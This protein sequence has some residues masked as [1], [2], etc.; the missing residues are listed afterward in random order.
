MNVG[1]RERVTQKRVIKLF[2]EKLGYTFLGNWQYDRDNSNIEV[3]YLKK[4]LKK[5]RYSAGLISKAINEFI[6]LAGNQQLELYD[7]NK[8][9]YSALRYGIKVRENPGEAPKTVMLIDWDN[10]KNNEFYIAEEVTVN[11]SYVK[12]PDI[13]IYVNGIALG[14]I[15]LKKSTVSVSKGIRQNIDNQKESFIKQFFATMGLI[16]AGNDSEGIAYGVIETKEKYYLSWKEDSSALDETSK[17]IRSLCDTVEYRLDKN[18]ISLCEKHRFI[19]ILHDFIVFDR[20]TKKACRPNQ[21]FGV[22][23]SQLRI[24]KREGGIVWHTQG[25]GKSLTMVWLTKWIKENKRDSRILVITDR[26]ELDE[27]IEKVYKGVDENIYRTKSGVDLINNLNEA[28]PAMICSLI[29]KFGKHSGEI[30]DK[31]YDKYIEEL[32]QSLPKGFKPKGDL[33]VFVDECHRTQSGKLH[34]AMKAILPNAVF[35]GFTGTPILQRD[36]KSSVEIFGLP[37]HTYKF[38]E[39]VADN[40]VLDLRYEAREV[41]Q[42]IASQEKIDQW[43]EVK[44]RGLTDVAKAQLKQK[45][46]TMQKVFSSKSR[47]N[48]IASDI[49]FDISTKGRLQNGRGNAMLIARNVYEACKY[50]ELFQDM[51]LKKCAIITSYSPNISDIKGES[52]DDD[53]ETEKQYKYDIYQ[54]MLGGKDQAAFEKDVKDKFVDEPAQMKLLIVVDKL[55]TGFDAPSATYL[56]IDKSMRDHG[57]FQAICRVNRLDG[58]DKEYGYIVDYMDLFKSLEKAVEDYTSEVFGDYDKE[59]VKGLLKDRLGEAKDDL[60][61][62][63]ESLNVLCEPIA[64]QKG[65]LECQRY[66]CG[67]NIEDINELK[68]NEPKRVALYKLTASL[69]R[70]YAEIAPEIIEAGYTTLQAESIKREVKNYIKLRD[71]IKVASGDYIDLKKC[72]PD[73]RHLID[74]YINADE[75]RKVSSLEDMSLIEIIVKRGVDFVDELPDGIKGNNEASAETI[76]NNVRRKIIEKTETNP[77]YFE[78]MSMLLNEL[79][80]QRKRAAISYEEYLKKVV[81]LSKKVHKQENDTNYPYDIRKSKALMSLYDNLGKDEELAKKLHYKILSE[82]QDGWRGD[83]IKSRRIEGIIYSCVGDDDNKI[84]E[85]FKIAENQGEY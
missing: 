60:E 3:E 54:K 48:K 15:E 46:G 34:K 72:E 65:T 38:D 21:Y 57:L 41:D 12:R 11:G 24:N 30:S 55:L 40:V 13:I 8:S 83:P 58:E 50:Y 85:I 69:I 6:S 82:R 1:E 61:D 32:K 52:V 20:G 81:E 45:W 47:L 18:I 43:F 79:I 14:V 68:E 44:T 74:T 28:Q 26:T 37:I 62:I 39:A 25:S 19:E 22:K 33:Y 36:K 71:E 23:A 70:A 73:M 67:A 31:D 64:M 7:L 10:A 63:L 27:Q 42:N 2:K 76:E 51:G 77:K 59:D 80:A 29:H 66:F 17:N 49:Y 75:V 4:F 5:A 53:S 35:I 9:V 56:Y 84:K 16:M 78:K